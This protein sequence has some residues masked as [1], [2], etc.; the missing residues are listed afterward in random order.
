MMIVSTLILVL[1]TSHAHRNARRRST[2]QRMRRLPQSKGHP[3]YWSPEKQTFPSQPLFPIS[4]FM[5]DG[6]SRCHS[7]SSASSELHE[8]GHA[9]PIFGLAQIREPSRN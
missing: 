6:H 9:C 7:A 1:L 4:R 3:A 2:A 5:A 8:D